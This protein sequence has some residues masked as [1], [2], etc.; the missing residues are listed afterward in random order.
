MLL[1][2]ENTRIMLLKEKDR[3][4]KSNS[5]NPAPEYELP[6]RPAEEIIFSG[7]NNRNTYSEKNIR[8]EMHD[9]ERRYLYR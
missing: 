9:R 6:F 5:F 2:R 4:R 8:I 1:G 3:K 7:K